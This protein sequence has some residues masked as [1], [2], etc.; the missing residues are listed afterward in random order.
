MQPERPSSVA[1]THASVPAAHGSILCRAQVQEVDDNNAEPGR[2]PRT[3]EVE[4]WEDL[5]DSCIPGDEVVVAGIVKT[6]N[7]E[8]ASGRR[9]ARDGRHQSLYLLYLHANTIT[10]RR[11]SERVSCSRG[12]PCLPYAPTESDDVCLCPHN[13]RKRRRT[14]MTIP[15]STPPRA[16]I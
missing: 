8:A 7:A 6:M 11:R 14:R 1:R 2:M 16:S 12:V 5:V 9:P 15:R 4:L 10:N 13:N 3:V